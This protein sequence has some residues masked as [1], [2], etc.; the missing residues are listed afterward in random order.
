MLWHVDYPPTFFASQPGVTIS[1]PNILDVSLIEAVQSVKNTLT[2]K[3]FM[4]EHPGET[5]IDIISLDT[6]NYMGGRIEFILHQQSFNSFFNVGES[7]SISFSAS[8][9]EAYKVYP[10]PMVTLCANDFPTPQIQPQQQTS[11]EALEQIDALGI[12]WYYDRA[13]EAY[14][15]KTGIIP[16]INELKIVFCR[17]GSLGFDGIIYE[18]SELSILGSFYGSVFYASF[19]PDGTL[20]FI[21]ILK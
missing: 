21:N 12:Q 5:I 7:N 14:Q 13:I 1:Y 9:G 2:F 6:A 16:E 8:G 17:Y 15:N 19:Q 4:L 18:G 10:V 3:L 11:N 20:N